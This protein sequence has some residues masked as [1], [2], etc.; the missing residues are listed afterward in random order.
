[1]IDIIYIQIVDHLSHTSNSSEYEEND[2]DFA[3]TIF[4]WLFQRTIL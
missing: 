3:D 4:K 2:G 1:M